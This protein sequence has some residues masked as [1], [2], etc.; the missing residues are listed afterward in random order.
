M[1][2]TRGWLALEVEGVCNDRVSYPSMMHASSAR[3]LACSQARRANSES[4][5]P[6]YR[7]SGPVLEPV[8]HV[9]TTKL[10]LDSKG[11]ECPAEKAPCRAFSSVVVETCE[12][13][14]CMVLVRPGVAEVWE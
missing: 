10:A 12:E 6:P 2:R 5:V 13:D 7:P 11:Y 14:C 9:L 1:Q 3:L 4:T 8:T